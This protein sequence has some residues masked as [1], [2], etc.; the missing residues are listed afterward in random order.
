MASTP[1][2]RALHRALLRS[3]T[4]SRARSFHSTTRRAEQYPRA[5]LETFNK[6]VGTKDRL[7][8]VDFYA[9]WCGPCHQL[10]PILESLITNPEVKSSSGLPIDLVKVNTDDEDGLALGQQFK[11]RALPTVIAFRDG[12]PV[13]QFVGAL[14]EGG[15]RR[16]LETV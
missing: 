13:N 16:F 8:L 2:L 12:N 14:P 6:V 7:V 10:S 1:A 5:N 9:D 11:V 3:A 4:T 15:V